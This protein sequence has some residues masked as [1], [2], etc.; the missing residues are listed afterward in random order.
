MLGWVLY[1]LNVRLP[2]LPKVNVE[3][4]Q[5][6]LQ[7]DRKVEIRP[8]KPFITR[9]SQTTSDLLK[10]VS[11]ATGTAFSGSGRTGAAETSPT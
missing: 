4:Y 1:T 11:Q 9:E 8:D 3:Q 2:K 5:K 6:P 7:K 10:K